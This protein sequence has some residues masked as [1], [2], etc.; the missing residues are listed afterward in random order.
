MLLRLCKHWSDIGPAAN[1]SRYL[2]FGL[3][4]L[5]LA[6]CSSD[7]IEPELVGT[8]DFSGSWE[9]D[10][11]MSD[12][13]MERIRWLYEAARIQ[14]ERRQRN[15][16]ND[17]RV[18]KVVVNGPGQ[19]GD[20]EAIIK[21][22]RLAELISR[23]T[24]LTIR[25][26][27]KK[28]VIERDDDFAL[29]CD[30]ALR[31]NTRSKLGQQSCRWYGDQILFQINLPDGLRVV[32]L[33]TLAQDTSRLNLSTTVYSDQASHP[34]TLNRVFMPFEPTQDHQYACEYSL[35]NL[36]TCTLGESAK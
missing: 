16:A 23:S 3:I 4:G 5:L 2:V 1:T 27:D 28:I 21:L 17:K 19:L 26:D 34:F 18:P 33:L 10:G 36:N 30:F 24:V 11:Q 22:G 35:A 12:Q 9:L 14:A 32:H 7:R 13:V 20:V 29:V 25:Q 8:T 15:S 6:A 31:W